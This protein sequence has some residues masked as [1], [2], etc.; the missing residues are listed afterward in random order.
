MAT[1]P[2]LASIT[3][4]SREPLGTLVARHL[5][6]CFRRVMQGPGAQQQPEFLRYISGEAH[7]MGNLA[8]ISDAADPRVVHDAAQPLSAC[9]APAAVIFPHC[10]PDAAAQAVHGLGF[11]IEASMPAMAVDIERLAPTALP[12]AYAWAR[13]GAGDEADDWVEA[14]AVGYELPHRLAGVFSPRSLGADPAPD[15]PMQFFAVH[16]DGRPVATVTLFLD[17][18]LAGIYCVSTVPAERRRGLG[19]FATAQALR[20]AAKLG[21]RVGVLQSSTAGHGVYLGLGFADVGGIPMF[22]RN[23]R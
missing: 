19:A 12:A 20:E 22:I 11:G 7:P 8:V 3:T 1:H 21:Y 17:D 4:T 2:V 9:G 5:D 23:P 18:G 13:C 6:T 14:L 10:V 16:R 15:A